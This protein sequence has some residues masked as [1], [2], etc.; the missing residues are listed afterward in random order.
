MKKENED[1]EKNLTKFQAQIAKK[2][3]EFEWVK[4]QLVE[5]KRRNE[6]LV[7]VKKEHEEKLVAKD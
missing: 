6:D 7:K 5:E 1:L 3:D 4:A 2:Q